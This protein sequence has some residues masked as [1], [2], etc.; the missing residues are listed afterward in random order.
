MVHKSSPLTIVSRK[1]LMKLFVTISGFHFYCIL[2]IHTHTHTHTHT[3]T[4]THTQTHIYMY[5]EREREREREKERGI[6]SEGGSVCWIYFP[7]VPAVTH[8]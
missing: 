7:L 1:I 6:L 8:Y 3:R 5:R 4:R 2:S